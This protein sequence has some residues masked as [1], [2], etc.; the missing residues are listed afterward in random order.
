MISQKTFNVLSISVAFIAII[1]TIWQAHN[2]H[3][4]NRIS[5]T[6]VIQLEAGTF[7][8][9]VGARLSNEGLGP[10]QLY[11]SRVL[12]NGESIGIQDLWEKFD[13][14]SMWPNAGFFEYSQPL[15]IAQGKSMPIFEFDKNEVTP[16]TYIIMENVE[17]EYVYCDL[18]S[19]HMSDEC[20]QRKDKIS[21]GVGSL[22]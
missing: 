16:R 8:D 4:V 5:V 3:K 7:S 2:A 9:F 10:A 14:I 1:L 6:P 20:V 21:F 22:R 15:F 19:K 11:D 17:L 13:S 12:Y 18:F